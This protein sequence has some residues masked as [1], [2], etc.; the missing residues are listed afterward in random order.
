LPSKKQ[1]QICLV[2][3]RVLQKNKEQ[4]REVPKSQ[5]NGQ[6]KYSKTLDENLMRSSNPTESEPKIPK[7]NAINSNHRNQFNLKTLNMKNKHKT[8]NGKNFS[9]ES[10]KQRFDKP[11]RRPLMPFRI[12]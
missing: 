1:H 12:G 4:L 10:V 9:S 11:V 8:V 3:D 7:T 6:H 5:M 2:L